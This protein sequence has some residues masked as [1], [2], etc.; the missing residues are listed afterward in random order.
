MPI[1]SDDSAPPFE[2][3]PDRRQGWF[4]YVGSSKEYR[5]LRGKTKSGKSTAAGYETAYHLTGLYPSWWEGWRFD[6]GINAIA[7]SLTGEVTRDNAQRILL[8]RTGH[9]G[10]GAIPWENVPQAKFHS[11]KIR[12]VPNAYEWHRIRH[13]SGEWSTLRFLDYHSIHSWLGIGADL[14]WFDEPP[15]KDI[16]QEGLAKQMIS[17]GRV[18]I[19]ETIIQGRKPRNL[20]EAMDGRD[21]RS[22]PTT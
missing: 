3:R 14:V 16:L 6:G 12:G 2:Y 17:G 22:P 11:A 20:H 21:S 19:T 15:P 18:I 5:Y 10:S 1:A 9:I 4:H 13:D 8:G 7:A